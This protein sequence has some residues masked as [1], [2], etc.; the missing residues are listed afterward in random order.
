MKLP[1]IR[2]ITAIPALVWAIGCPAL[3]LFS[4]LSDAFRPGLGWELYFAAVTVFSPLAFVAYG[5]DKW[6]AARET[7][8][9]PEKRL[10]LLAILGGWPGAVLGQKWFRHKMVKPVF[11]A[12]L[13]SIS[14]LHIGI[15]GFLCYR[16]LF[17]Q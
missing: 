5:W 15:A 8:R 12:V 4:W 10:H 6:R 17:S 1:N 16:A 13:A 2:K 14:G 3:L 9:I 7:S 11:R